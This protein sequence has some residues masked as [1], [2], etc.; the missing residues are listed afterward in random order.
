MLSPS[1]QGALHTHSIDRKSGV[2][3]ST[4]VGYV[5][6]ED[7]QW[8]AVSVCGTGHLPGRRV[9]C[10][11]KPGPPFWWFSCPLQEEGVAAPR[12]SASPCLGW[13]SKQ[14]PSVLAF[15]GR[16]PCNDPQTMRGPLPVVTLAYQSLC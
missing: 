7:P 8:A 5:M 15:S 1:A 4:S 11:A 2:T 6:D 10:G 14:A 3:E 16:T 12:T 9:Q 13:A